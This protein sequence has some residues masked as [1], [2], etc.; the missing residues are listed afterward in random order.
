[1]HRFDVKR[2]FYKDKMYYNC[3][4]YVRQS[5]ISALMKVQNVREIIG[6][7]SGVTHQMKYN[8]EEEQ[9]NFQ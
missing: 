5:I 4:V 7:L 6:S 2:L 1:M 3:R 8:K 9:N